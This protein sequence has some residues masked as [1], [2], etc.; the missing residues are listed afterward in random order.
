MKRISI[1]LALLCALLSGARADTEAKPF[2]VFAAHYAATVNLS[3]LSGLS[4]GGLSVS[5][6]DTLLLAGQTN[7]ADNGLWTARSGAWERQYPT[8]TTAAM[9][10]VLRG[11][12]K[13]VCLTLRWAGDG[14][15]PSTWLC[16]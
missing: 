9:V 16:N 11:S 3:S 8:V 13:G 10:Y 6:G 7:K 2:A 5:D 14:S 12:N 15:T 4:P 1:V